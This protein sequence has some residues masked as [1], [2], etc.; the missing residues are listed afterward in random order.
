VAKVASAKRHAQ[1]VFQIALESDS[2]ERW[3]SDLRSLSETLSDPQLAAVLQDPKVHLPQKVEMIRSL[4]PGVGQLALNLAFLLVA[5]QRLGI[6]SQ[7]VAAYEVMADA[8]E[9]VEHASVVTA[10]PLEKHERDGLM[11]H[12]SRLTGKSI[13]LDAAVD[14]DIIGGFVA[15]IG[16]KLID[17]STKARLMA[18][19]KGL[20]RGEQ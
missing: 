18:L 13:V 8:H 19:K 3:R 5:R 12:L 9:G 11:G 6:L 1:A 16:D 2:V 14:P 4:V 10:V 15:R 17:G 20:L 7:L